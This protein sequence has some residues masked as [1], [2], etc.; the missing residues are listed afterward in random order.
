MIVLTTDYSEEYIEILNDE[1]RQEAIDHA[2]EIDP[3]YGIN[4]LRDIELQEDARQ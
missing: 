4:I 3:E 1:I 2:M